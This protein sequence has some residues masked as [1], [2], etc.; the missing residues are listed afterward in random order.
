MEQGLDNSSAIYGY[1]QNEIT[2]HITSVVFKIGHSTMQ[3]SFWYIVVH[4]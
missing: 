1:S 3:L 2:G 4:G